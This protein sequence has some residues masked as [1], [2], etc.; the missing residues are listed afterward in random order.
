MSLLIAVYGI[1]IVASPSSGMIVIE[2][3]QAL[4]GEEFTVEVRVKNN[5]GFSYLELTPVYPNEFTLVKIENGELISDFTQGSKQY[6][7]TDN[8]NVYADGALLTLTFNTSSEV[9][10][11]QY[12][13]EFI[14][15]S[16]V[17]Y[18]EETVN[19]S[20]EGGVVELIDF[21]YGD[22]TGDKVVN[23][24]D[25]VRLIKYLANYDYDTGTSTVDI[26]PGA[27]ANGDGQIS[28]LDVVRLKKYMANYDYDT[29]ISTIALGPN[30]TPINPGQQE[31]TGKEAL[32]GY[33]N[34]NFGG[35]QFLISSFSPQ[36][37]VWS[38]AS[39]F[40]VECI[41]HNTINDAVYERNA[42]MNKLYNCSIAVSCDYGM[43]EASVAA[44]EERFIAA[45]RGSGVYNDFVNGSVEYYN[46]LKLGI[47]FTQ[48]WW[49]QNF[50]ADSSCDGKLFGVLGDFSLQAMNATWIMY[51]N[52]DVYESIFSDVDIYQLVKENKWTMDVMAEMINR[53][54]DDVN[55]DSVYTYSED[56]NADMLGLVTTSLN[57]S[58]LYFA[59]GLRY[60]SKTENTIYGSFNPVLTGQQ[61]GPGVIDKL[62]SVCNMD[63]YLNLDYHYIPTALQNG[64]TLF[65]SEV[66][67]KLRRLPDAE[68]HRIGVLPQPLYTEGQD[69]YHCYVNTYAATLGVPT[70][71]MDIDIVSNFLTLFAYHSSKLVRTAF[72][73]TYKKYADDE[74]AGMIDIILDSRVYDPGYFG[75]LAE[76]M[77]NQIATMITSQRNQY[78][79]AAERFDSE[80]TKKIAK[81][82]NTIASINDD[83]YSINP[84]DHFSILRAAY[85][86]KDGKWLDGTFTLEGV[87][88]NIVTEYNPSFKNITYTMVVDGYE[89]RPINAYNVKG[90]GADTVK[91]GDTVKV[92]GPI[93]N[94]RGIIELFDGTMEITNVAGQQEITGII[95][96]IDF[97]GGRMID[98]KLLL[99]FQETV[100]NYVGSYSVYVDESQYNV[101][102]F[103][104]TEV[105]NAA[106]GT[107]SG[108][109]TEND[110]LG[111]FNRDFSI[112]VYYFNN[113]TTGG[114]SVQAII[115]STEYGGWCIAE[116]AGKPYF[117]IGLNSGGKNTYAS[118]YA[119]NASSN[120][121]LTHVVATF[122]KSEGVMRIYVDGV[123]NSETSFDGTLDV[124]PPNTENT[125]TSLAFG[126]DIDG[127]KNMNNVHNGEYLEFRTADFK[128]IDAKIYNR[129]LTNEEVVS[130]YQHDK[131]AV[132][133]NNINNP[134][135][136]E[137]T[138]VV[139]T[140]IQNV[141]TTTLPVFA[142][143][144]FG[145]DTYA[146]EQGLTSHE[147]LTSVLA[148]DESCLK[149]NF[150]EDY[151][152]VWTIAAYD[153]ENEVT[154]SFGLRNNRF[155]LIFNDIVTFDFD[156]EIVIGYG[157]Y[158]G[159]P[160][161]SVGN[162]DV[163]TWSGRHQYMQVRLVNNTTNNIWSIRFIK[164]GDGAYFTTCVMGNLY[165]QGGEPTSSSDYRRTCEKSSEWA[166]YTYDFFLASGLSSG[167]GHSAIR[168]NEQE[169]G[170]KTWIEGY[171]DNWFDYKAYV[172]AHGDPG[173]T[174]V[175]WG[176]GKSFTAL[177]LNIF[178]GCY[179]YG[180]GDKPSEMSD[181]D[182]VKWTTAHDHIKLA[183]DTRENI[184]AGMNIKLDYLIFGC[185]PGQL[186]NYKSYI[187]QNA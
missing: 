73:D 101:P 53:V 83:Y 54:K 151:W 37:D 116:N 117:I 42:V 41:T 93:K 166:T 106:V 44:G 16:C 110:Y 31:L 102:A 76:N 143:F 131:N 26:N 77:N 3:R 185:S 124:M 81:Y 109:Q 112:E 140:S 126:A 9:A 80:N 130:A 171:P 175:L 64:R 148:Y 88:T 122:S 33:E 50:I 121:N 119:L 69:S 120:N 47:D 92:S 186:D 139:E 135:T 14:V 70:S 149:V 184:I 147:Y 168:H 60:I 68:N 40:W 61:N 152:D 145:T 71:F 67:D 87:V 86:L 72:V 63:G 181:D 66:M 85:S 89:A 169:A 57:Y 180:L 172:Y 137:T 183:C 6:I 65:A 78:T 45:S 105:G 144:D 132:I 127:D 29:G 114:D 59:S 15:R 99:T 136:E 25:V 187:E 18:N 173:G 38:D 129:A 90:E 4:K 182:W 46:L 154:E 74:N 94:N 97:V 17:N 58:G 22:A 91:V 23:G 100:D 98:S 108:V 167:R 123:L 141:E 125:L 30:T 107:L 34:V 24:V 20:V 28:G 153:A 84:N 165:L 13:I 8:E 55:D 19:M 158:N 10:T 170:G 174:N 161:N 35:R 49:D 52:K 159:T 12:N 103:A 163:Q 104:V 11:G 128:L 111:L 133:G 5:P 134:V 160:Y 82:R 178:S 164:T 51:F 56:E 7:W 179:K 142:R 48:D 155:A 32:P 177:E 95:C 146:E 138:Q 75:N 96:D 162:I 62:I 176:I 118:V 1:V 21:V 27:D 150:E 113:N 2:S 157:G 79:Q 39:D 36:D 156:D 43:Y 115:S